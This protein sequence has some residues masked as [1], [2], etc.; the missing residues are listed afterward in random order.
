MIIFLPTMEYPALHFSFKNLQI[1]IEI[2]MEP[3]LSYPI[4]MDY[5]GMNTYLRKK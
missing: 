4:Q 5:Y 2:G 3:N 1:N